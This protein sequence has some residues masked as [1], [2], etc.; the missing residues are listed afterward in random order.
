MLPSAEIQRQLK[1]ITLTLTRHYTAALLIMGSVMWTGDLT[2]CCKSQ[3]KKLLMAQNKRAV[4]F[5]TLNNWASDICFATRSKEVY[6]K[7]SLLNNPNTNSG[8]Q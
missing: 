2:H 1:L 3:E 7:C 5:F 6:G 8:W 4:V